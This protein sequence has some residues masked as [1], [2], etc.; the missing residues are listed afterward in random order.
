[1][2]TEIFLKSLATLFSDAENMTDFKTLLKF[3]NE[4][5]VRDFL[6]DENKKERDDNHT[7]TD[8]TKDDLHKGQ[9]YH[10]TDEEVNKGKQESKGK[11]TQD[12]DN[13]FEEI[14]DEKEAL[15]K[16]KKGVFY[17]K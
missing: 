6:E 1:M 15:A 5:E 2:E 14:S 17:L 7:E 13:D 12:L 8:L 9:N 10:E 4:E 11:V 16:S 3:E